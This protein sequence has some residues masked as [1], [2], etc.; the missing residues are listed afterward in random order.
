[1]WPS[2]TKVHAQRKFAQGSSNI[3]SPVITPIK[4]KDRVKN[5]A[6]VLSPELIPSQRPRTEDFLTFLCFRGKQLLPPSLEFFNVAVPV[7][8]SPDEDHQSLQQG[9]CSNVRPVRS[10]TNVCSSS[11]RRN[12]RS[13][14]EPG[15]KAH[16]AVQALK[17]KYQEQR[18]AK[19]RT[20]LSKLVQK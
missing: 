2:K 12:A 15:R 11:L 19:Q 13:N 4:D 14:V 9:E 6:P 10:D 16:I 17:K 8:E 1:M 18:L 20:N 7:Q 5:A 3:S